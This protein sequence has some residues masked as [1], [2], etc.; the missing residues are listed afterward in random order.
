M[1]RKII[2]IDLDCY[3]AAVE[4][5]DNPELRD[6]PL[7]IGGSQNRRGVISTCNYIARKFGVRSAM[8]TAHALKLCPSLT[9]IGGNMEKYKA[10]S[11]QIHKIFARYTDM[12]EPLSLDEA[13]L[14]VTESKLFK[15]SATLI[16]E[17]IRRAIEIELGL[18]ASAGVAPIKFVA[19]VASDINKPNGIC[20]VPP[21]EVEE[22]V[23]NLDLGKIPGVGKVTLEKL[24]KLGLY[25]GIDV[26]N[27]D[28]HMLIK[29]FGKFGTSLWERSHAIDRREV[30]PTRVRKSL[31]VERTFAKDIKT[32]QECAD[33]VETL[34]DELVRRFAKIGDDK[35]IVRQGV[36][37]KFDDFQ[38]TTVEHKQISLDKAF[39]LALLQEALSRAKGRG[40]RLIG[41]TVGLE[42]KEGQAST[43][44]TLEL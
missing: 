6:I 23:D 27:Y 35:R 19:K 14:D 37:L 2:H 20:V 41:L 34:Y 8:A 22:F 12:I 32:E 13:Y 24:N 29:Q 43:Q 44:M 1:T 17:D 11:K 42:P 36:K 28:Q 7:A 40:I 5:R 10:V 33:A 31:G 38:Q 4:M 21:N 3:Y 39:F 30:T 26:K 25:K 9:V 16:A 18:T 15:G